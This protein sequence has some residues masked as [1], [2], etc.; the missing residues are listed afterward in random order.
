MSDENIVESNSEAN[1]DETVETVE[2]NLELDSLIE[3][4]EPEGGNVEVEETRSRF[5]GDGG[6]S[7]EEPNINW[8]AIGI[9]LVIVILLILSVLGITRFVRNNNFDGFNLFSSMNGRS[10]QSAFEEAC[11]IDGVNE[12]NGQDCSDLEHQQ[13]CEE[14]GAEEV[15]GKICV[16]IDPLCEQTGAESINGRPCDLDELAKF[17]TS[18]PEAKQSENN[19]NSSVSFGEVETT[20]KVDEITSGTWETVVYEGA[21]DQ[22]ISWADTLK[23]PDAV[24]WTVFPNEDHKGYPAANGVE[25]GMAESVYGQ[26][27]ANADFQVAALHYRLFTGDYTIDGVGSCKATNGKGCAIAVFNVGNVTSVLANQ[28][29]DRGFTVTG[30]YW[31]GDVMPHA[32]WALTSHAANSMLNLDSDLNPNG[33]TN[34]GANCSVPG[35]CIEVELTYVITSGNEV[36]MVGQTDVSK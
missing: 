6:D 12:F 22:M 32:I 17:L 31:N 20:D 35:G 5:D 14:T 19:T 21:T 25:Y 3:T 27:G 29:L 1:A 23:T 28:D 33:V 26:D 36:L 18:K 15:N 16:V 4:G 2:R 24:L 34:A 10:G 30:R 7:G 11:S 8:K 13:L 9:T